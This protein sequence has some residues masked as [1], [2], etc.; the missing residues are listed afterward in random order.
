MNGRNG[1]LSPVSLDSN[2]DWSPLSK[3]QAFPGGSDSGP[4]PAP[5]QG[6]GNLITPPA[7]GHT[8]ADTTHT[9]GGMSKSASRR[10]S[11]GN[12]SP[13][14]SI[15]RSSDGTGL[16]APSMAG[17]MDGRKQFMME[18]AL[19]EHYQTVKRYLAP[20]IREERGPPQNKARDKLLRL[21]VVQ[22]QELSTDVYDELLRREDEK[23]SGDPEK[24]GPG[25]DIPPYLLPKSNFHYK[26]NQARQKLSTLPPDRFRQLATDVFY[27]LQR[28]FPRFGDVRPAS[29]AGSMMSM[30]SRGG[31]PPPPYRSGPPGPPNGYRGPP[32]P[33]FR[34]PPRGSSMSS[35]GPAPIDTNGKLVPKS[36][37]SNT[38]VPNKDI[39]VEDDDGDDDEMDAIMDAGSRISKATTNG[40]VSEKM[41][42]VHQTQI[43]ALETTI[44]GLNTQLR[45]KDQELDNI[46]QASK[47]K[48]ASAGSDKEEWS[49]IQFDLE[50]KL[51][52]AQSLNQNLQDELNR[53]Q[54]EKT[55][56]E[57]DL[58]TQVEEAREEAREAASSTAPNPDMARQYEALQNELA[59]QQRLTDEVR[60]EALQY[61]TEMRS[62]SANSSQSFEREE[63]L[64]EQIAQL[65]RELKDWKSRYA[66][67]KTQLRSLRAS[68]VGLAT[69]PPDA[70]GIAR[71]D[72]LT[73]PNGL[74]KDVHL[75]KF[76][77]SIDELLQSARLP[78]ASAVL[79]PMKQVVMNVRNITSSIEDL[80]RDSPL[81]SSDD[82]GSANPA[83]EHARAKS[84]VSATANN[85]ITA[86]KN[87]AA[88]NGLSPVSLIDAAASHLTTSII[89]LVKLVK[90]RPTP[91]DE[92]DEEEPAPLGGTLRKTYS[93]L[94]NGMARR[95]HSSQ[96]S[97][98]SIN[99]LGYSAA[100]SPR[101]E[102][103]SSRTSEDFPGFINGA[104]RSPTVGLG[105]GGI[106][107]AEGSAGL[108]EYKTYLEDQTALLVQNIQPLVNT[109][110]SGSKNDAAIDQYVNE[111]SKAIMDVG[112]KTRETISASGNDSLERHGPPVV[113]VLE[114]CR[115]G[116]VT[117]QE[118]GD[119]Q[120]MPP[121]AFRIARA[122]KELVLRVDR[123]ESG[124][125]TADMA[126]PLEM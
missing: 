18:E 7:S 26:R 56:M 24:R 42:A 39:M 48:E 87:H 70:T 4:Y 71:D 61:L 54:R 53:I 118:K 6:K 108:D 121:I 1:P 91:E 82:G 90:I 9:D 72:G 109:I 112:E 77:I 47:E 22:F 104:N 95:T 64:V 16:Y 120:G 33:Q 36:F 81:E 84:R 88:A 75:T 76:Q 19:A 93:G 97:R 124:E 38:I 68:S 8:S 65:E 46:R 63:Q 41:S 50:G 98:S 32:P 122:T 89:E 45:D 34:A 10:P 37:Q 94:A 27:E 15:A 17:S 59:D 96:L 123:I 85:L 119:R 21:S 62:M 58:R 60:R 114:E 40:G 99:S 102:I 23:R 115:R 52:E 74:V 86:S 106:P 35:N 113:E 100:S 110:R 73:D 79:E 11:N 2:G 25:G 14:S 55:D 103:L 12:P 105:V 49:R 69:S 83:K 44:A 67:S 117:R 111:I 51:S 66:R 3:Y 125:L 30:S 80:P 126:C 13:P 20:Y 101:R 92:L 57:I 78:A 43:A 107:E 28:R 29:P 116:L 5:N 31:G